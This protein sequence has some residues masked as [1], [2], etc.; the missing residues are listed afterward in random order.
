MFGKIKRFSYPIQLGT[1][2]RYSSGSSALCRIDSLH[3]GGYHA[4][5]VYG[6]F[7]FVRHEDCFVIGDEAEVWY[8]IQQEYPKS[9]MSIKEMTNKRLKEQGYFEK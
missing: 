7:V 1:L 6:G 3:A 8:Q 5:Q 2:V 4:E 9:P